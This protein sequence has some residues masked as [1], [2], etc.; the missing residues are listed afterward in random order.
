MMAIEEKS[1]K[2]MFRKTEKKLHDYYEDIQKREIIKKNIEDLKRTIKRKKEQI[3]NCDITIEADIQS[4][5]ITE[6][7]QTSPTGESAV[8]RGIERGITNLENELNHFKKQLQKEE[9]DLINIDLK[10]N[11][12][13]HVIDILNEDYKYFINL[14]YGQ[15]LRPE[16]IAYKIHV[17]RK[18]VYN[19]RDKIIKEII[20]FKML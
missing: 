14:M 10:I 19:T 1:N 15:G 8:E 3:R 4:V 18:T 5:S 9:T 12:V 17:S 13:K 20:R 7:V 2:Y 6:R 16:E 11:K